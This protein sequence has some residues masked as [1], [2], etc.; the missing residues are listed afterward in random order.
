[1]ESA[2]SQNMTRGAGTCRQQ[3]DDDDDGGFQIWLEPPRD[4]H[5]P[6]ADSERAQRWRLSLASLL[7]LAVLL[8]DLL[9]FCAE[10]TTTLARTP[11]HFAASPPPPRR[12]P[13]NSTNKRL[14]PLESCQSARR[15]TGGGCFALADAEELCAAGNMSDLRLD[16]CDS[17]SLLDLFRGAASP[18][19]LNCSLDAIAPGGGGCSDCVEAYRRYDQHAQEKYD[20]FELL[21][22]KYEPGE[23]SVRTCMEQCKVGWRWGEAIC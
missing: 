17:Y 7:F 1:M 23:Y 15:P 18:D 9:R 16:F 19:N 22:L 11:D 2:G 13:G 6:H 8:C 3:D 10:A 12:F 21:A 14:Y 20:D 4:H 5:T